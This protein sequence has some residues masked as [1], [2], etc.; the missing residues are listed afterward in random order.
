MYFFMVLGASSQKHPRFLN[1]GHFHSQEALTSPFRAEGAFLSR[2]RQGCNVYCLTQAGFAPSTATT[3]LHVASIQEQWPRGGC[4]GGSSSSCLASK[5]Y[6]QKS[7]PW[8]GSSPFLL[9]HSTGLS[10]PHPSALCTVV[11]SLPLEPGE[12]LSSVT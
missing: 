11:T 5:G 7:P 1:I 6:I 3:L 9:G 4:R 10:P 2:A 8:R 12:A